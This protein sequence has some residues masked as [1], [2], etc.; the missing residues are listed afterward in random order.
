M[1]DIGEWLAL[2]PVR[3]LSVFSVLQLRLRFKEED[4]LSGGLARGLFLFSCCFPCYFVHSKSL[5]YRRQIHR[6]HSPPLRHQYL[7]IQY[8]LV[9]TLPA[10]DR[11]TRILGMYSGRGTALVIPRP[12]VADERSRAR[13][14][15]LR[16]PG[17]VAGDV[18]CGEATAGTEVICACAGE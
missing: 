8:P 10:T 5:T 11:P 15:C 14:V 18:S 16:R 13:G 4:I 9:P 7:R 17:A 3:F 12:L 1:G 6:V 2:F